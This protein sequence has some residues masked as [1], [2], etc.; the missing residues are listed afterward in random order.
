MKKNKISRWLTINYEKF[1]GY[2]EF[3]GTL[4]GVSNVCPLIKAFIYLI[5]THLLNAYGAP[6]FKDT[7]LKNSDL[8]SAVGIYRKRNEFIIQ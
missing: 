4:G 1:S 3:I 7:E 2:I 5:I 8:A 6:G